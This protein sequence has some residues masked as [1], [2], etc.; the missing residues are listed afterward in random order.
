MSN[1]VTSHIKGGLG[2][3]LFQ[4]ATAYAI[5]LRDNKILKIDI[6]DI[7]EVHTPIKEY[8]DNIFRKIDFFK[9]E[10]V[11]W[12]FNHFPNAPITYFEIPITDGNVKLH[13]YYQ[14]DKFFLS[15]SQ[16]IIDLFE[17]DEE[18]KYFLNTKYSDIINIDDTCSIHVRRG[19]YLSKPE[20][21]PVQSI[22]Y[23]KSAVSA[24]GTEKTFLI[25]SDD[26]EWCKSNFDFIEKKVFIEGNKD[27]QDLYLMSLCKNNIITNSSFSW[28][29]AFLNKNK[30]KQV[31][32]PSY[33]HGNVGIDY[34]DIGCNSWVKI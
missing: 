21:H 10:N 9:N 12:D 27:Y 23:Y 13:G 20:W 8:F 1:I 22:D 2:N 26:I 31:F 11:N 17:I 4:I 18:T 30:D 15:Y 29:G 28:W 34:S 5:S 14:N 19:D 24:V 25:F 6:S 16:N 3:F 7:A 33:W 32:Y